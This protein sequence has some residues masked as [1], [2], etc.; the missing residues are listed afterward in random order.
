MTFKAL[1]CAVALAFAPLAAAAQDVT[2]VGLDGR[3]KVFTP[4]ELADLPRAKAVI[5]LGSGLIWPSS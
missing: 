4:A 3:T 5:P 2:V 1:A